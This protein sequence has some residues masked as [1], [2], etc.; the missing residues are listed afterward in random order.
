TTVTVNNTNNTTTI[1]D[2]TGR[3]KTFTGV[4][5]DKSD[6]AH[7][8][9]GVSLYVKGNINSLRRGFDSTTGKNVA[10]LASGSRITVTAQGDITVT[11]DLTYASPVVDSQ[12]LP[13]TNYNAIQNVLGLF[14]NNGNVN[15]APNPSYNS[16]SALSLQ[17]HA[18]IVAFNSDTSD[19]AGG[20]DGSITYT[21]NTLSST[22][23]WTL[24]G[25]RVQA[26]INNIGYATRNIYFDQRFS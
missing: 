26:K 9:P 19:D 24:V 6:T 12:G 7:P 15:L 8:Q 1:A 20:I 18:A 4:P 13:V 21:G 22:D 10:G 14:T 3:T 23:K 5:T 16:D 17:V 2:S 25:S 11:G